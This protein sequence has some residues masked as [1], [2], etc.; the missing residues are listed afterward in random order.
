MWDHLTNNSR[1][2]PKVIDVA[3]G[4]TL[5]VQKEAKRVAEIDFY[6]MCDSAKGSTDFMALA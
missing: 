1:G 3:Q 4:R 2:A 6:E 5:M